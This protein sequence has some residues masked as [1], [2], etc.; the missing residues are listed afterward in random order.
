[1]SAPCLRH[2]RGAIDAPILGGFPYDC[3]GTQLQHQDAPLLRERSRVTQGELGHDEESIA[4][5]CAS[6][7]VQQAEI[8]IPSQAR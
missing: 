5:W 3:S 7:A 6:E 1:M 4:S 8:G 2:R